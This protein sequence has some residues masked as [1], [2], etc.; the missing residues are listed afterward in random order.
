MGNMITKAQLQQLQTEQ[1]KCIQVTKL[2]SSTKEICKEFHIANIAQIIQ[3][4]NCKMG[5]NIGRK[6]VPKEL[7]KVCTEDSKGKNP[8]E[9]HTLM[10][11]EIKKCQILQKQE[12]SSIIP[13]S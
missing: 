4:E 8:F 10:K 9:K 11:P 3:M 5:Y 1:N 13:V 6:L 7:Y 12:T 2:Q